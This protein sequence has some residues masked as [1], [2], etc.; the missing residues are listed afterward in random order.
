[1]ALGE[2]MKRNP[3][4]IRQLLFL[5]QEANPGDTLEAPSVDGFQKDEI[6]EHSKLLIDAGLAEGSMSHPYGTNVPR[7]ILDRLTWS[8]HEFVEAASDSTIWEKVVSTIIKPSGAWT[9]SILLEALKE[10]IKRR[11]GLS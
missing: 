5:L 2:R 4:L 9:F 6:Y 11:S 1:V 10:E 8:G 7:V 3:D